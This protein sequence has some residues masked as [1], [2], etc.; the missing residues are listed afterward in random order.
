MVCL[1]RRAAA[2]FRAEVYR[3]GTHVPIIACSA[4]PRS[5]PPRSAP[6]RSAPL[7]SVRLRAVRF[8]GAASLFWVLTCAA[9]AMV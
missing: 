9:A 1:A 3:P 6:L 5:A 2:G 4:P 7:R 8:S